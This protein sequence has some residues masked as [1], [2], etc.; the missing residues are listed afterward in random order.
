[1]HKK[2]TKIV[3]SWITIVAI[4]CTLLV[5]T[6]DARAAKKAYS[7][8]LYDTINASEIFGTSRKTTY[9]TSNKNIVRIVN[10]QL[11]AV[12]TGTATITAKRGKKKIKRKIKVK[13]NNGYFSL[14]SCSVSLYKGDTYSLSTKGTVAS[15][16]YS[17]RNTAVA[18]VNK[19]GKITA[20]SEGTTFI[21]VRSGKMKNSC[22]VTVMPK[23]ARSEVI[24]FKPVSSEKYYTKWSFKNKKKYI[25][26][27]YPGTYLPK[28]F[29]KDLDS[30]IT[31][32]EKKSGYKLHPVK[33]GIRNEFDKAV[34]WVGGSTG[35]LSWKNIQ[36]SSADLHLRNYAAELAG[37][38]IANAIL[39]RNN[40]YYGG[41]FGSSLG[42]AV[43]RHALVNTKYVD[44]GF[45][46]LPDAFT[47]FDEKWKNVTES[48]M[49]K[50]L[51]DSNLQT[52]VE[53]YF[54][55]YIYS[56]YG[57]SKIRKILKKINGKNKKLGVTG[58]ASLGV[59]N[60]KILG[61]IKSYTSKTVVSDFLKWCKTHIKIS[62]GSLQDEPVYR[63]GKG[64][65]IKVHSSGF[66]IS[67]FNDLGAI[68]FQESVTIDFSE[69]MKYYELNCGQKA[70]G[71][72]GIS[73]VSPDRDCKL[74][75]YDKNDKLIAT[76]DS[77]KGNRIDEDGA[78]K[79]RVKN[80]SGFVG[81]L[82]YDYVT[83]FNKYATKA[84]R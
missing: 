61:I 41:Q 23:S 70:T 79:V 84:V 72:Y 34:I 28:N 44:S 37:R 75:V 1:M 77:T 60:K 83:N 21:D 18:T 4:M 66:G 31:L 27:I 57:M 33:S 29:Q 43:A 12:S 36:I 13:N 51:S 54:S 78:V 69:A 17:S 15:P 26:A 73:F 39:V 5:P 50:Y 11:V 68:K 25:L 46:I 2:K 62:R 55:D 22:A 80:S 30:L 16:K 53:N 32:L 40:T 19:K 6:T 42:E 3:V 14:N 65:T 58:S 64:K 20:K 7:M 45:D 81:F 38:W 82:R 10:K 52:E 71:I 47:T 59:S 63:V 35:T 49:T 76:Y 24:N 56:K 8:S 48:Q 9:K 74:Y 67:E